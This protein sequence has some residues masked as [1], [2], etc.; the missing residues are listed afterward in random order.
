[1]PVMIPAPGMFSPG[2][3]SCAASWD[4]SRKGVFGSRSNDSLDR[5]E[6]IVVTGDRD[7]PLS[8]EPLALASHP[9]LGLGA[10]TLLCKGNLGPQIRDENI[11]A[12]GLPLELGRG[13]RD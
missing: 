2:Y 6:D 4:N 13:S 9:F 3:T 5:R 12:L 7:R 8:G 10:T 11:H 1:M